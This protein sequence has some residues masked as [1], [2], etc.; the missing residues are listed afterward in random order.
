MSQSTPLPPSQTPEFIRNIIIALI[1]GLMT[2]LAGKYGADKVWENSINERLSK[3]TE[4]IGNNDSNVKNGGVKAME[5]IIQD[6]PGKQW[7]IVEELA[8]LVRKNSPVPEKLNVK[9]N[10]RKKA[11]LEVK[12]AITIIKRRD[13]NQ[14]KIGK[15]QQEE[16]RIIDLTNANL[17]GVDLQQAQLPSANLSGSDLTNVV[18]SGANLKGAYL[19]GTYLRGAGLSKADLTGADLTGADL[20]GAELI[21]TDLSR[22]KSLTNINLAGAKL[23]GANFTDEQIKQT[24][25]WEQ[26][27]YEDA[28]I[29]KALKRKILKRSKTRSEC[30]KFN[31]QQ[32][33]P[34]NKT[35]KQRNEVGTSHKTK[36]AQK[37]NSKKD[38]R[39][40]NNA[41]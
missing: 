13:P 5:G 6:S 32:D 34:V 17:F 37:K 23:A 20:G 9:I 24:C 33:L 31:L 12:T 7:Q 4:Q 21:N 25:N 16:K 19:R 40:V 39:L 11:P 3:A 26:A 22:V 10:H 1:A 27:K 38:S 2:I 8:D 35:K 18:L 15:R 28:D 30:S 36:S 29:L 41:H 14:D